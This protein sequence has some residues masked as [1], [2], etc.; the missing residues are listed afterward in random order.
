MRM[1]SKELKCNHF[2]CAGPPDYANRTLESLANDPN[3]VN[4]S[5]DPNGPSEHDDEH[6]E[7]NGAPTS[8]SK[9]LVIASV[10]GIFLVMGGMTCFV[11]M[12]L[13]KSNLRELYDTST[14]QIVHYVRTAG[15]SGKADDEH[16]IV[17][18]EFNEY[19]EDP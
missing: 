11:L 14:G 15:G 8:S 17:E 5:A 2:R 9:G 19:S 3:I 18:K 7:F 12:A 1:V 16:A 4:C 10:F 13:R 6:H